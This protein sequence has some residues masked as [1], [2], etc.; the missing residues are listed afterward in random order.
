MN[1]ASNN[2]HFP[3]GELDAYLDACQRG[4]HCPRPTGLSPQETILADQL[5]ALAQASQPD[6]RFAAT[7]EKRLQAAVGQQTAPGGLQALRST[8]S[9]LL[10]RKP[11]TMFNRIVLPLAGAAVLVLLAVF[12]LPL[13]NPKEL[14]LLPALG[15]VSAS[16]QGS[17]SGEVSL[18]G[19]FTGTEFILQTELPSVPQ[20]VPVFQR[21]ALQLDIETVRRAAR[22]FD[23]SGPVYLQSFP[24]MNDAFGDQTSYSIFDGPRRVTMDS[25]GNLYYSSGLAPANENGPS[26]DQAVKIARQFIDKHAL[27]ELPYQE[28]VT[29]GDT[30]VTFVLAPDGRPSENSQMYVAL[31]PDGQ[32]STLSYVYGLADLNEVGRYPLRSAQQAWESLISGQLPSGRLEFN[33]ETPDAYVS[34]GQ[35][36]F[37]RYL[38]GEWAEIS[39]LP[40][41]FTPAPGENSSLRVQVGDLPLSAEPEKL[42][43]L[44]SKATDN[45]RVWGQVRQAEGGSLVLEM[46]GWDLAAGPGGEPFTGL[47]QRQ[48]DQ[49]CLQR[50]DGQVFTLLHTSSDLVNGLS[51]SGAGWQT[52][53][54]INGYPVLEWIYLQSPPEQPVLDENGQPVEEQVSYSMSAGYR[55][56]GEDGGTEESPI[57]P[58]PPLEPG[59]T[60]QGLEGQL[61]A[62]VNEHP[63][64]SRTVE[65]WLYEMPLS[66]VSD[67]GIPG[68]N[69]LLTGDG[70]A[71][72][73][74][75]D[76]LWVRLWG[77]YTDEDGQPT[78]QVERYEQADPHQQYQAWLG[79]SEMT[80]VQGQ[81]V[82]LFT[83]RDG[84]QYI[85][86]SSLRQP[87]MLQPYLSPDAQMIVEGVL[88][89]ETFGGF[90]VIEEAIFQSAS[91]AQT[92]LED[93][94]LT[95]R[96]EVSQAPGEF[97]LLPAKAYIS[98]VELVYYFSLAP[99]SALAGDPA[100]R[101]VQPV[102]R[103]SGYTDDG[104][105]FE[106]FIQAVD[107]SHIQ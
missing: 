40:V 41:F 15:S 101:F 68:W 24:G 9:N 71:G 29:P 55:S 13:L 91:S 98:K 87:D 65:A 30:S 2:H 14:P 104:S 48:G 56:G 33:L 1:T 67:D 100:L 58:A 90:P 18:E 57:A 47:I 12:A 107:D 85:L 75:L 49:V 84:Q 32:M 42:Q 23:V 93:Y 37:P 20:R 103:F 77:T 46:E 19:Y 54:V 73:E 82:A 96:P 62:W 66:P 74:Q 78:I 22:L 63:D 17:S 76:R 11:L 53:Q 95:P 3:A 81:N 25:W 79:K 80:Q 5:L 70:M 105:I 51:V 28:E 86:A 88:H 26:H 34:A 38:P 39:G 99:L 50:T 31:T 16:A 106:I 83:A 43:A 102:W 21:S 10:K 92:S 89:P 36:W 45:M 69:I 44:S 60:V 27:F 52:S 8:F 59:Q 7:L 6:P 64:G 35:F 4:E 61:L 97:S 94:Q 72:I